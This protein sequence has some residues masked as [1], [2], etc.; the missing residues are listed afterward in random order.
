MALWGT[1]GHRND[2]C[3]EQVTFVSGY[4]SNGRTSDKKEAYI[5]HYF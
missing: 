1:N 2:E 4:F 3:F 5:N